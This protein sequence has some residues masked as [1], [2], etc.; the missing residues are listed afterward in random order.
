MWTCHVPVIY[1]T[2]IFWVY[3]WCSKS[4]YIDDHSMY[5]DASYKIFVGKETDTIGDCSS[6]SWRMKP[7]SNKSN[8]PT[9][10]SSNDLLKKNK[11]NIYFVRDHFRFERV[12]FCQ[13]LM[14]IRVS[15]G[16]NKDDYSWFSR[17][18]LWGRHTVN[19]TRSQIS[20]CDATWLRYLVVLKCSNKLT[21]NHC[22]LRHP[23]VTYWLLLISGWLHST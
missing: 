5:D 16:N 1:V 20:H 12:G 15:H 4:S 7:T 14:D 19:V 11:R 9:H 2:H 6:I 3:T 17:Q 21:S 13:G 10:T 8:G 18:T 23:G 22:G